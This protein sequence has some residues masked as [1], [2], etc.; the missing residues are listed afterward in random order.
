MQ[1]IR[2]VNFLLALPGGGCGAGVRV[3]GTARYLRASGVRPAKPSKVQEDRAWLK[4]QEPMLHA[5]Y[6]EGERKEKQEDG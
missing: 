2:P 3:V 6:R 5:W 4:R 1:A